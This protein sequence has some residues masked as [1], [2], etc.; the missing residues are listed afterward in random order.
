MQISFKEIQTAYQAVSRNILNTPSPKKFIEDYTRYKIAVAEAYNDPSMVK[1]QTLGSMIVNADL[2]E[3]FDQLL[4]KIYAE[5]KI[6]PSLSKLNRRTQN[7][8]EAQ[9]KSFYGKNP[10]YNM[11]YVVVSVSEAAS[12]VQLKQAE[13]RAMNIHSIIKK[14]KKP[15]AQLAAAHSDNPLAGTGAVYHSRSSLY[16]LLYKALQSLKAGQISPPVQTPNG[17]YILKLN[18]VVPYKQAGKED[19]RTQYYSQKRSEALNRYF[20][21]LKSGYD[22]TLNSKAL[23]KL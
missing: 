8:S 17:F 3:G 7:L 19:I 9:L 18:S 12:S 15:F 13:K 14:S 21:R 10:Y 20:N 5:K 1:S 2:K 23:K 11:Q 16:P 6:G 4:Y 22:V